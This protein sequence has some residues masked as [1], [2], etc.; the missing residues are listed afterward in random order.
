M[1]NRY[2]EILIVPGTLASVLETE[3]PLIKALA[4][5]DPIR[6]LDTR[7]QLPTSTAVT[8]VVNGAVMAIPMEGL[9]D[10]DVERKRLLSESEEADQ[11]I[12]RLQSR[13]SD[14]EFLEKAP[15][16]VIEREQERL[17]AFEERKVHLQELLVQLSG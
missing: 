7:S 4:K 15:E 5:V 16:D 14:P 1:P 13:L 12:Q 8:S 3:T 9:I 10:L 11:S 17:R 2:L 6:Y